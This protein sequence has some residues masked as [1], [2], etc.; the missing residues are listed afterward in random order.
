MTTGHHETDLK[1][2]GR[3]YLPLNLRLRNTDRCWGSCQEERAVRE[4]RGEDPTGEVEEVRENTLRGRR[5]R[6]G[7]G[8]GGAKRGN[9]KT[10][11]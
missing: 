3:E 11:V 9:G 1:V 5:W 4:R 7:K 2:G 8:K 10:W 6:N